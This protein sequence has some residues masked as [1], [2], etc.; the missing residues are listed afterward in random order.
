MRGDKEVVWLVNPGQKSYMEMKLDQSRKPEVDEKVQGEI[1]RKL[2]G[3][4][5][6]DTHPAQ[7]Y[8][9]TYTAQG[10]TTK[11]YQWMATDIKFPVK[12]AAVDGSW[13][14][15]YKNIKMGGQTDDLF[16][17]PGGYKRARCPA[18]RV[19]LKEWQCRNDHN[20]GPGQII[21]TR[22]PSPD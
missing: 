2:I 20:R 12:M 15:E 17:V 9:V 21:T 13:T 4:E 11:M 18:Y 14:T 6:I 3:S 5:T 8:E 7:K 16:E 10:K 19:C 1:S 22:K